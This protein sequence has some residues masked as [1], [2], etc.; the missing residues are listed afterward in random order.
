M[1]PESLLIVEMYLLKLLLHCI[2]MGL[3]PLAT[4]VLQTFTHGWDTALQAQFIDFGYRTLT[5]SQAQ[6]VSSHY[7]I[8]AL[9]KC[10]MPAGGKA[11]TEVSIYRQAAAL[12]ALNPNVK[13]L[14][15]MHT[16][17]VSLNCYA[18]YA[19]WLAHPEWWLRDGAGA[20]INSTAGIPLL[21]TTIPAAR[22]WWARIPLNGTTG[23]SLLDSTNSTLRS[24]I[25]GVLA[26]GAGTRC[27]TSK[28]NASRCLALVAG[29]RLMLAELQAIIT[30]ANGGAVF[31]NGLDMS[32]PPL[33]NVDWLDSAGALMYEH[34][35]V[36]EAV[37]ANGTLDQ[38]HM[39]AALDAV[40][41]A[42][43]R[44]RAVVL[45]TWPGL[46]QLPFNSDGLASWPGRTQPNTTA[47][48]RAALL[49][50]HT[51]ALALYLIAAQDNVWMQYQGWYQASAG[52][53][54][55]PEAPTSC[56]APDPWYPALLQPLGAPLGPAL[57]TGRGT[58]TRSF[59]HAA[60]VLNVEAPDT[61]AV[62]FFSA[63]QP[64]TPSP[65]PPTPSSSPSP[66]PTCTPTLSPSASA[67]ASASTSASQGT[68]PAPTS[69]AT[70]PAAASAAPAASLTASPALPPP[71]PLGDASTLSGGGGGG[72]PAPPLT[73]GAAAALAVGLIL[74]AAAG[75]AVGL[76]L[77]QQRTRCWQR[78]VTLSGGV[79]EHG[80]EA[81][82]AEQLNPFWGKL[83]ATGAKPAAR[84]TL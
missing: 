9:E 67:S 18:Q 50:K 62:T 16:D 5:P 35:A 37:R 48:W 26:D 74:A 32:Q 54:A 68:A 12:K 7:S 10:F 1:G 76:V 78:A 70:T 42:A 52:A 61:S 45:A 34:Y 13:V 33:Y 53:V 19:T 15:Y 46:L 79:A 14:F 83:G 44:G 23:E 81:G 22:S 30:A 2:C 58:W 40:A 60:V 36:F 80:S 72:G 43:A 29:K 75:G 51:F 6:F 59:A 73:P 56:I 39:A 84:E 8:I 82:A 63:T 47:G 77:R 38:E 25:D 41:S 31:A 49:Q 66:S 71:R 24:L 17:L 28:V 64:P 27:Q 55:C 4:P 20:F 57:R 69:P 21:D 11:I 3:L 65:P